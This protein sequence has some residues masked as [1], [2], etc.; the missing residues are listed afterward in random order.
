[1]MTPGFKNIS[2]M[3]FTM[4]CHDS[5]TNSGCRMR[6]RYML[7]SL[8]KMNEIFFRIRRG[9]LDQSACWKSF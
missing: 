1:M 2:V 8:E 7:H 6:N 4:M 9:G 3:T 5:V